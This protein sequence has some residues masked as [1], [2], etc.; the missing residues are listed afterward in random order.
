[1][2]KRICRTGYISVMAALLAACTAAQVETMR[3][4]SVA[5]ETLVDAQACIVEIGIKPRYSDLA[6]KT[7]LVAGDIPSHK[8]ADAR[9]LT[10]TDS[11]T[12]LW[13]FSEMQECRRVLLEGAARMHPLVVT[14]FIEWFAASDRIY[15]EAIF[16]RL[17]WGQFNQGLKEAG[18]R[19]KARI[20]QAGALIEANAQ[21]PQ[22][23]NEQRLIA[24]QAFERWVGTQYV[25]VSRRRAIAPGDG[26]LRSIRCNY[27]GP[28]L[29]C[30]SS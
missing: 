13:Y 14:V 20:E 5:L 25:L 17:T 21:N 18:L 11:R 27:V 4:R 26:G 29:E 7:H 16:G 23:E 6:T 3:I 12:L 19:A 8:L 28:R 24:I 10:I 22:F 15:A 9:L 30:G 2:F 1:V